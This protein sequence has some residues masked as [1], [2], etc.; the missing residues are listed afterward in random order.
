MRRRSSTETVRVNRADPRIQISPLLRQQPP[1]FLFCCLSAPC[2]KSVLA[3]NAGWEVDLQKTR[4]QF[5]T[6]NRLFSGCFEVCGLR[7]SKTSKGF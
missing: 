1:A 7:K 3:E 5:V 6:K 4:H 2:A